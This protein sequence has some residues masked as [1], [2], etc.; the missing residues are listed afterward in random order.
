M[1]NRVTEFLRAYQN[2]YNRYRRNVYVTRQQRSLFNPNAQAIRVNV[3]E[4]VDQLWAELTP[5]QRRE[6]IQQNVNIVWR[7]T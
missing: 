1:G 2:V 4:Q 5:Q 3:W 6:A 7:F